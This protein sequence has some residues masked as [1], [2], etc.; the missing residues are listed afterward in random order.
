MCNT[1]AWVQYLQAL[2]TPTV[3]LLAGAIGVLQWRTAHLRVVLDVFDRRMETYNAVREAVSE[4]VREG[5]ASAAA[6]VSFDLATSRAP[7]LFGKDLVV[8]LDATR[9]RIVAL[10]A[11]E[12]GAKTDDDTKRGK[13]ADLEAEHFMEL[14]TF[15]QKFDSLVRPYMKMHQKAPPF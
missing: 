1:P 4:I 3:A 6:L 14:T 10:R 15:Y 11:A 12:M 2:L 8:F 5:R 13:F 9:K 7:F